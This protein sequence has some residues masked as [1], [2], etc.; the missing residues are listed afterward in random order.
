M[1]TDPVPIDY[2]GDS[3]NEPGKSRQSMTP[4]SINEPPEAP[5]MPPPVIS[6]LAPDSC[7]IGDADFDLI[8][9]GENFF[10]GSVI[11][12]AG[13]DEPTTFDDADK[14]LSTSVKPSL[15]ANPVVVQ[16][17]VHNGEVMSNAVDFTFT[18]AGRAGAHAHHAAVADPDELEDELEQARED[19]DFTPT[20]ASHSKHKKRKK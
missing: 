9:S 10:G 4:P 17:Q 19:D 3:I 15:W 6:S 12:F 8:V 11:F 16:C 14:T 18:E 20:H 1:S 5:D 13:H 7:A 2:P